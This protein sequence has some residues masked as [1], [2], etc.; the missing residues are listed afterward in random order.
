MWIDEYKNL[1]LMGGKIRFICEDDEDMIEITYPDGM[2]IDVGKSSKNG[3]YYITVVSSN[4]TKGWSSPLDEIEVDDKSGL[5]S[6]IQNA[7]LQYRK[8]ASAEI[9][10]L[11][12]RYCAREMI[13]VADEY[14]DWRGKQI[15]ADVISFGG[16]TVR[17]TVYDSGIIVGYFGD[18]I[19]FD[20]DS[21]DKDYAERAKEYLTLLFTEPVKTVNYY[22]K[23]KLTKEQYFVP[24][25]STEPSVIIHK[26]VL[27]GRKRITRQET[28]Y[29]FDAGL[30]TFEKI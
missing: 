10:E 5:F 20:A 12:L 11:F 13:S 29:K 22:R 2:A 28:V 26:I 19:H 7:I 6:N 17:A 21:G 18:H 8:S 25:D 24:A 15:K 27:F 1:N 14:T 3:K 4:D 30:Q 23:G 16:G 9:H